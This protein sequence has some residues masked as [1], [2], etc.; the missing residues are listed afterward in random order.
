MLRQAV[1]VACLTLIQ[2]VCD[3]IK[4]HALLSGGR[5]APGAA[6]HVRLVVDVVLKDVDLK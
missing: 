3:A 6:L 2:P 5:Q 1:A 4:D